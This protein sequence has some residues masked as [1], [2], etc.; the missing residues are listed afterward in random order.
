MSDFRAAATAVCLT[1]SALLGGCFRDGGL[2]GGTETETSLAGRMLDSAGRPAAGV[3]V[4]IYA[5]AY[6][7]VAR[8][9]A[10][11]VERR[12]DDS[13]RYAFQGIPA[14]VYNV[15]G[16]APSGPAVLIQDAEAQSQST[17]AGSRELP[18]GLLRATGRILVPWERLPLRS[19]WVY[20]PGTD[21]FSAIAEKEGTA[22]GLLIKD[23]PAG[24]YGIL[25]AVAAD[26]TGAGNLLQEILTV[27]P[28]ETVTVPPYAAWAHSLRVLLN[29]T[30][31]GAG[32][33]GNVTL[34]PLLVRLDSSS[35]DFTE[36]KP[37]GGDVRFSKANGT[38]LPFQIERWDAT[39]R[40]AEIWVRVDTV[41]GDRADQSLLMHYGKDDASGLSD[42][43]SVFNPVAGFAGVWHLGEDTTGADPVGRYQDASGLGNNGDDRV[44]AT[45]R[46]GAIGNGLAFN[47]VDDYVDLP[48]SSLLLPVAN[49]PF[50]M[51]AWFRPSADTDWTQPNKDAR[52]M[53][54]HRSDTNG[55]TV[56]MGFGKGGKVYFY[57]HNELT[58]HT[59]QAGVAP[60][61]W[62][63]LA[64]SYDGKTF[65]LY[66]DGTEALAPVSAGLEAGGSFRAKI[67]KYGNT[68]VM[69]FPGGIDEARFA[70]TA[71]S[72]AWLKLEY[73][74]Q[75]PEQKLV[76]L[77][78]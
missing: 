3:A 56:A 11:P 22:Q 29:T 5:R 2:E 78:P 14:G 26:G 10:T 45:G 63:S 15:E 6:N 33:T 27:K 73:E 48:Q 53:D 52:I 51:S 75:R 36:A 9:P 61:I 4:R 57:N 59:G 25:E 66:L 24:T 65:R 70:R 62:H 13:G 40:R 35:L 34:F 43:A 76:V 68:P 37:D 7:P 50:T 64:L 20:L 21:V 17:A 38:P 12:T 31:A 28:A 67:G 39:A 19:G 58:F 46:E 69:A 8:S 23:V 18:A 71:R 1:L 42:G 30:P 32:V 55:S 41:Y 44:T 16:R 60:G 54:V 77:V 47:G 72:A 49:Q 74:G